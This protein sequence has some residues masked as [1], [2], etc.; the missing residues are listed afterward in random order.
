M[1]TL[2]YRQAVDCTK[3]LRSKVISSTFGK[4]EAIRGPQCTNSDRD[5]KG[6]RT[7]NF[8]AR[9]GFEVEGIGVRHDIQNLLAGAVLPF[10]VPRQLQESE[11]EYTG[12]GVL[13]GEEEEL[14]VVEDGCEI[15]FWCRFIGAIG[16]GCQ[17]HSQEIRA[18]RFA[19][20]SLLQ[21]SLPVVDHLMQQT[22]ESRLQTPHCPVLLSRQIPA[23]PQSILAHITPTTQRETFA[24]SI[25]NN[26]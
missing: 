3:G 11:G 6:F 19:I 7:H 9:D 25:K 21:C 1:S 2:I 17:H 26:S 20:E 14:G 8:Q 12:D 22:V 15:K 23:P 24:R 5:P 16:G 4:S 13:A 18:V 10:R